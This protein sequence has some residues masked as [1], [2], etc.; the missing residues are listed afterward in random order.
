MQQLQVRGQSSYRD[1]PEPAK[2]LSEHV[3]QQSTQRRDIFPWHK[4][5]FLSVTSEKLKKK[6]WKNS[7]STHSRQV[8]G[9]CKIS[10]LLALCF[11]SDKPWIPICNCKSFIKLGRWV[12]GFS[13]TQ[14]P[15]LFRVS[16]RFHRRYKQKVYCFYFSMIKLKRY[17]WRWK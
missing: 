10:D 7:A 15:F 14:L 13:R 6:R 2:N 4:I 11:L 12:L 3:E 17:Q 8:N 16:E 9:G 5:D 1:I